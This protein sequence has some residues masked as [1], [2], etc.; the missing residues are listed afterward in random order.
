MN[1]VPLAL[2]NHIAHHGVVNQAHVQGVGQHDGRF[3]DTQLLKLHQPQGLAEA[4]EH[5][6]RG[7]RLV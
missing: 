4:V 2:V 3:D 7:H 1:A 6:G 5:M